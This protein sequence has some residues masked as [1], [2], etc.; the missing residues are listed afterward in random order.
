MT[1]EEQVKALQAQLTL[2]TA[3]NGELAARLTLQAL[4]QGKDTELARLVATRSKDAANA[5]YLRDK[6]QVQTQFGT[7]HG[8]KEALVQ[9]MPAGKEGTVTLA[10]GADGT[11]WMR[12][13]T[14]MFKALDRI[15]A[16]LAHRLPAATPRWVVAASADVE[17]ALRAQAALDAVKLCARLLAAGTGAGVGAGVGA[18]ALP[19]TALAL[20]AAVAALQSGMLALGA[21]S[22]ASRFFR[23]DRQ[24]ALFDGGDEVQRIF[25][26][27]L[28]GRSLAGRQIDRLA[29]AQSQTPASF[30]SRTAHRSR[31]HALPWPTPAAAGAS[32]PRPKRQCRPC[33]SSWPATRWRFSAPRIWL[34]L[35]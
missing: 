5:E 21:V 20:P 27:L 29:G 32:R 33:G 1:V 8:L 25:E 31:S 23:V 16:C 24:A 9:A 17:A 26:L 2:L 35:P 10:K 11:Q 34:Q 19:P 6:A 15:A 12:A 13:R 14:P 22:D 3:Q 28:Q 7:A 18:G 30:I 4:Q